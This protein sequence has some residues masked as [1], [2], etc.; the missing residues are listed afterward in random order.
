M[1]LLPK[2]T[3]SVIL[4][5]DDDDIIRSVIKA[6]LEG[7]YQ[8]EEFDHV[9]KA[10]TFLKDNSVDLVLSDINMPDM[11]G[12]ELRDALNGF[13]HLEAVPF[14]FLTGSSDEDL[15]QKARALGIDDFIT[16]PVKK[17]ELLNAIQPTL[18][19]REQVASAL[20]RMLDE[21]ITDSLK[22]TLPATARNFNLILESQEASV[23]GG[24]LVLHIP[25]KDFD[26]IILAD[27]MGHGV[28]AKFFAH[29]YAGYIYGLMRSFAD[30]L[31]PEG[32]LER[33]NKA[34]YEDALLEKSML[35]V[36]IAQLF[37]DGRVIVGT[38][39]HPAPLI[40]T[41]EGVYEMDCGGMLLGALDSSTYETSHIDLSQGARLLLFS[42]GLIELP[43]MLED[44]DGVYA[45]LA[46]HMKETLQDSLDS[47]GEALHSYYKKECK[48][49]G[50]RD[51]VTYVLLDFDPIKL[52]K[53]K[54]YDGY[55]KWL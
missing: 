46:K 33:L 47:A 23:G 21:Q 14:I 44:P 55:K 16:K 40:A 38:A 8:V 19:R 41:K 42:D 30:S 36:C 52:N 24:D 17:E 12:L 32:F 6:Y 34:I 37:P 53:S 20:G 18:R 28:E 2:N 15:R 13:T 1:S 49:E 54:I 10:L 11:N 35:T 5:V 9:H 27:V 25:H 22:P 4:L 43:T 29:A 50:L 45:Q 7:L 48:D 26:F 39:G 31:S 51:D 3:K